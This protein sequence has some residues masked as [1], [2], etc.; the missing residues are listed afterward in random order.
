MADPFSYESDIAPLR[1]NNFGGAISPAYFAQQKFLREGMDVAREASA[2]RIAEIQQAAQRQQLAFEGQRLQLEQTKKEI[3]D[4]L[5]AEAMYPKIMEQIGGIAN[6]QSLDTPTKVQNLQ[7]LKLSYGRPVFSNPDLK[8]AFD[9]T[10]EGITTKDQYDTARLNVGAQLAA[11]GQTKAAEAALTGLDPRIV[12]P[13]VG[14]AASVEA[15]QKEKLGRETISEQQELQREQQEKYQTLNLE[16]LKESESALRALTPKG[17]SGKSEDDI[18]NLISQRGAAGKDGAQVPQQ[19]LFNPVQ[20]RELQE[21][22]LDLNPTLKPEELKGIP[23]EELFG[24]A[25][26]LVKRKRR[27]VIQPQRQ[28]TTQDLFNQ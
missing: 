22:M 15:Q 20:Q 2:V 9:S 8:N 24:S 11:S 6:D 12:Q 19:P 10:I 4:R 28:T 26:R 25:L 17:L 5:D 14:A 18:L 13:L 23:P 1:G 27:S 21:I 3:K 16:A 7:K